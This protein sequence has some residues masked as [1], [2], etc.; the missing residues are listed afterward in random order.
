[1]I[2]RRFIFFPESVVTGTPKD[3]GLDFDDVHFTTTDGINLHGWFVPGTR[4]ITWI[5]FHGNAGNISHRLENLTLLRDCLGIGLFLFDYRGYGHSE[6]EVSEEGTYKDALAALDDVLSRQ[7]VDPSKIVYFGRSLGAA[8]AVDLATKRRPYGLILESAFSSI[9]DMARK[10]YPYLPLQVLVHNKYDSVS[11]IGNCDCPI[12][13]I[14]GDQDDL[15]PIKQGEKLYDA[16]KEPKYFHTISGAAHNDT[17]HVGGEEYF[18][19]LNEF[20]ASLDGP[21][22]V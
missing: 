4:D 2:E 3:W 20:M 15:I 11:K 19:V 12:L 22:G 10:S 8:V 16:A 9:R 17:Y 14:H 21:T 5:W 13:V 7:D 18:R 6:G 1:M